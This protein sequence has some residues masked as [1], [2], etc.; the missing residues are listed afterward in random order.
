MASHKLCVASGILLAMLA[1]AGCGGGSS[2]PSGRTN[3]NFGSITGYIYGRTRSRAPGDLVVSREATP[4]SGT[5]G[6]DGAVVTLSPGGLS[7]TTAPDGSGNSGYFHFDN[8]AQ[9]SYTATVTASGYSTVTFTAQVLAGSTTVA[10]VDNGQTVLEPTAA[11]PQRKWTVM[12]Y[13]DAANDL[14]PFGIQNM[15]QMESVGS[16]ADVNILVQFKRIAG[17]DSTNGDWT[18]ARRYLVTKDSDNQKISSTMLQDLGDVDMAQPSALQQFVAWGA[19]QYPADHYAL[20]LWDHGAGWRSRQLPDAAAS[21]GVIFD[22]ASGNFMTMA[23]VRTGL[24][25]SKVH[26]DLLAIDACMM[27]MLETCYEF[28][29]ACDYIAAAEGSPPGAG[30]PYDAILANLAANPDMNGEAFGRVF[31]TD[32]IAAYPKDSVTESLI[33]TSRLP[34]LAQ[35]VDAFAG[36]LAATLP[37]GQ[38]QFDLARNQ[39]QA[40]EYAYYHDL[41]DFASQAQTVISDA[42]VKSTAAAVMQGLLGANGGPVLAEGHNL[43]DVRNSHGL[44][45]YLPGPSQYY[46]G[47]ADLLFCH[48]YPKWYQLVRTTSGV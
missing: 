19:A 26:L 5:V 12:V 47:Y 2:A 42:T 6:L 10:G 17:Y 8:V 46:S 25:G 23:D 20:V 22:D 14:E 32:M 43:T 31:V 48:D 27:G 9:G 21:R 16:T 15:N 37:A 13:M 41:Y 33:Q 24:S 38:T 1:V 4:P 3:A 18:G 39:S 35:K 29:D 34:A 28:K 30:Y 45:I 7:A 11:A 44:S 40:Y 36:A